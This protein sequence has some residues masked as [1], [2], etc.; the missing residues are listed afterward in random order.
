MDDSGRL[1]PFVGNARVETGPSMGRVRT[2]ITRRIGCRR[3]IHPYEVSCVLFL[4]HFCVWKVQ[5]FR[6]VVRQVRQN[7]YDQ[8]G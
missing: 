8:F 7:A 3:N 5:M 2:E 1:E 6:Q 4:T